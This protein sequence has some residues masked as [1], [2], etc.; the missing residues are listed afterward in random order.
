MVLKK[1]KEHQKELIENSNG[2]YNQLGFVFAKETNNP[3]YPEFLKTVNT[4]MQRLLKLDKQ[5]TY[6]HSFT[7][8]SYFSPYRSRS[9]H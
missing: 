3:G 9:W 2:Y 7:T 4:R 6:S 1:Y 8:H 5:K